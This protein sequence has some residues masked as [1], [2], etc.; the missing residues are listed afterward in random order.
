MPFTTIRSTLL[1]LIGSLGALILVL[2]AL[3]LSDLAKLHGEASEQLR[4][5]IARNLVARA[6]LS[7][8]RERDATFLALAVGKAPRLEAAPETDRSLTA[9]LEALEQTI[10]P[11]GKADRTVASLL[12]TEL[13]DLR[14]SAAEALK[15]PVGSRARQD[16]ALAWFDQVSSRVAD[17]RTIRLRFLNE[18]GIGQ[19]AFGLHYLRTHILIL[20]D[21]LLRNAAL[22][23]VDVASQENIRDP[24]ATLRPLN[25]LLAKAASEVEISIGPFE[26]LLS[27][28]GNQ[29]I[30]PGRTAFDSVLYAD[31]EQA[32]RLA[33]QSGDGVDEALAHWRRVSSAAILQLDELQAATFRVVQA[34]AAAVVSDTLQS[35][36]LWSLVL[37]ASVAIVI[38]TLRVVFAWVVAPLE[39]MRTAMLL[40]AEDNLN[41]TLPK[42]SRLKEIGAMDDALRVFKANATRRMALQR[43][44]HKL[45]GRL[46]KTYEHLK[47]D[48]EAAAKIQASLLPQQAQMAGVSLSSYFRPSHFLA[49][50]TFDVLQQPDGRVIV[51]QI[52]VAG[53]GAAAALVSVA[54][55]YTVAQ[56]ILQRQ[57][58]SDLADLAKE[59]NREWPSD[60]PYFT[61]LLA[62]IDQASG[63]GTLVQAGH[64]SPLLMR[65]DGEIV[66]L[67]DG[68]LPIGVLP[69][70]T[71]DA[72][73]FAFGPNDRL[74]IATDGFH[75]MENGNGEAFSEERVQDLLRGAAIR[76]T[77]QIIADLDAAM[78]SWRGD[79]TLDDDV[80]IVVL[81]GKL[82]NEYHRGT[83]GR[84]ADLETETSASRRQHGPRAA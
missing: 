67:G 68:G 29:G 18:N 55:K 8:A 52:D 82:A 54:S 15:L 74:M 59:I 48:L 33:M 42:Q 26:E 66:V 83:V 61:L 76:T 17:L 5:N 60:L 16:A 39:R 56:A 12:A 50:D 37:C 35:I 41:V 14:Q 65:P 19:E 53:H 45:H 49:G 25:P 11:T 75:E 44:R 62:E 23:E 9:H 79:D 70:A 31:A 64:P 58:G 38:V 51:F 63:L 3:Q 13:P 71:F 6:S 27:S 34:R 32:L 72:V 30:G 20:L 2:V 57:P 40:L 1:V 43:D 46:E 24:N 73:S 78:R 28:L 10:S 81:E 4:A 21:E 22:L 47:S 69:H 36:I 80:T 7:L 77:E 84:F